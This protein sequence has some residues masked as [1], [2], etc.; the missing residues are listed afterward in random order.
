MSNVPT[1]RSP[2][3]WTMAYGPF[4]PAGRLTP[5]TVCARPVVLTSSMKLVFRLMP[6]PDGMPPRSG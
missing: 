2:V 3:A 4:D 6:K 1:I 5:P